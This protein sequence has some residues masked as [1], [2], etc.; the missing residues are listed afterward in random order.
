MSSHEDPPVLSRLVVRAWTDPVVEAHGFGPRSSYV[1]Q[2]WLPVLGPSA[3][4]LYRRLG[5][6]V[7]HFPDDGIEVSMVDLSRALGLGRSVGHHSLLVRALARL[8]YFDAV[9]YRRAAAE[10][11]RALGPV[12]ERQLGRLPEGLRRAH[13]QLLLEGGDHVAG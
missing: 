11:R 13:R 4:W 5:T 3:T 6:L 2:L 10:V 1:E 7:N 8:S 9:R 12:S